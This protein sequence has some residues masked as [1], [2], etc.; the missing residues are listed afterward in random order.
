MAV[1]KGVS[2]IKGGRVRLGYKGC[3]HHNCEE[4]PQLIQLL[5]SRIILPSAMGCREMLRILPRFLM[6]IGLL[7]ALG[8]SAD[9]APN[10]L[11]GHKPSILRATPSAGR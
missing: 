8:S 4:V 10:C 7:V 6:A 2:T 1:P 11:K 9:A 3:V 5:D